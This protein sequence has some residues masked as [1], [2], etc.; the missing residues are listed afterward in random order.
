MSV[1]L[2]LCCGPNMFPGWRNIDR[3]DQSSYIETL[4]GAPDTSGWPEHQRR[5][6]EQVKAGLIECE[7]WDVRKGLPQF[8]DGSVDAIYLGQCIEHFNP[9]YEAPKLLAECKRMLRVG[10]AIRITTPDLNTIM[11]AYTRGEMSRFNAEQPA[12][13][14]RANDRARLAYLLFGAT[15]PDCTR[16]N[17]EGHFHIYAWPEVVDGLEQGGFDV[18][19]TKLPIFADCVDMGM[20]HSMGI[21]AVKR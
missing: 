5:L 12:Y 9:V 3:V 11:E 10:G 14:E 18:S 6:V 13:Y 16:E 21:N 2:N 19:G 15:G 4:R 8:E 7:A 20:S 17:Y 1:K